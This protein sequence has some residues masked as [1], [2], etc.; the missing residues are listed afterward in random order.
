VVQQRLG[1]EGE[2][3][4]IVA[5]AERLALGCEASDA[6]ETGLIEEWKQGQRGHLYVRLFFAIR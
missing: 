3:L 4:N 5:F 2:V 1:W 6:D